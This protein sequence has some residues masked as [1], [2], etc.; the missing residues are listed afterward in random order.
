[1]RLKLSLIMLLVI[2]LGLLGGI[3][4]YAWFT[5][6]VSSEK[7]QIITGTIEIEGD[8]TTEPVPLFKTYYDG[9][10]SVYDVGLWYPGKELLGENARNFTLRN[11]GTLKARIAGMSAEVTTFSKDGQEYLTESIDEWPEEVV[12]A[13]YEFIDKLNF[14]VTWEPGGRRIEYF[15]GNLERL[16]NGPQPLVST[17]EPY[18]MT[19][20]VDSSKSKNINVGAFMSTSANN[21]IQGTSATVN[22]SFHATQDNEEAVNQLLNIQ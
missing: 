22:I 13:Y 5:S 9:D 14:V 16:I 12:N 20:G 21:L 15:N 6:S 19:L 8:N 18:V 1:M 4:T 10:D 2:V 17:E 11:V 7:N 3:G